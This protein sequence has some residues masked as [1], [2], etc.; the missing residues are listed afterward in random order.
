MRRAEVKPSWHY[1]ANATG[2]L[3]MLCM[4]M[5]SLSTHSFFVESRGSAFQ[6]GTVCY[7][8]ESRFMV[9]CVP[10]DSAR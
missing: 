1:V 3:L 5:F 7:Y 6:G 9:L 4:E 10:N 2:T 8:R